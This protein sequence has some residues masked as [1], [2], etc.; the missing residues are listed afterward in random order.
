[1]NSSTAKALEESFRIVSQ[2]IWSVKEA[3]CEGSSSHPQW[4]RRYLCSSVS[5]GKHVTES[6][7]IM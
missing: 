6:G 7:A 2:G 5:K 4:M 3:H 1:M